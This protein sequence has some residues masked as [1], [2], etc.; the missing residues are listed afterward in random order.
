MINI[1]S[2]YFLPLKCLDNFETNNI[3]FPSPLPGRT[4]DGEPGGSLNSHGCYLRICGQGRELQT[5]SVGGIELKSIWE[6][7][8]K[9][10]PGMSS[11]VKTYVLLPL[12]L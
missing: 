1:C 9:K 2:I 5:K 8:L 12:L 7:R 4:K 3:Q 11:T 6:K 10:K